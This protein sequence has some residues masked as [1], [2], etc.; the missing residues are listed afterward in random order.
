MLVESEDFPGETLH[1]GFNEIEGFTYERGH[2]YYLS[3]KRTILANPPAERQKL[4][5]QSELTCK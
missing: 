5:K 4:H 1:L 3:V 2:E